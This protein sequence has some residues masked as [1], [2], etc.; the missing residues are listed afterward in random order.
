MET[1][2]ILTKK[3]K[4]LQAKAQ[5]G[6]RLEYTKVMLG[7]GLLPSGANLEAMTKLISPL[8]TL[9]IQSA[10][11]IGDG[12][13]RV[14]TLVSNANLTKGFFIREIGV[15]AKDPTEGEIL[16]SI[17]NLGAEADFLPAKG[18]AIVVEQVLDLITIVG[19]ATN[20]TAIIDQGAY[21]TRE[22]FEK[23]A[24]HLFPAPMDGGTFKTAPNAIKD[25]GTFKDGPEFTIDCGGFL[26]PYRAPRRGGKLLWVHDPSQ[27]EADKVVLDGG[28]F[29]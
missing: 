10:E 28:I 4:N 14:R 29:K 15:F 9:G 11:V 18:G 13:S 8:V 1:G 21:I 7:D 24:S 16:Y 26:R 27:Y 22:E 12:T 25:G 20:I 2:M 19:N 6:T 5:A 23:I 17:V 3:G